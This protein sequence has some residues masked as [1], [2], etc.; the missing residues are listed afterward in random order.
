MTVEQESNKMTDIPIVGR[1]VF[2]VD[3]VVIN[4]LTNQGRLVL[5]YVGKNLDKQLGVTYLNIQ[6]ICL[7]EFGVYDE[8]HRKRI[9]RGINDLIDKKV[10]SLAKKDTYWVDKGIIWVG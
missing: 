7:T 8:V 5:K 6:Q 4:E 1:F 3:L 10:I 2:Q 9:R